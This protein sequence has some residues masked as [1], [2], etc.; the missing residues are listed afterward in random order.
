[1]VTTMRKLIFS[2]GFYVLIVNAYPEKYIVAQ[3]SHVSYKVIAKAAFGLFKHTIVGR[4]SEVSGEFELNDG[5]VR[6][7][8]SI[9]VSGFESGNTR[10][11]KD[12]AKILKV[13]EFPYISIEVDSIDTTVI[14]EGSVDKPV[15]IP[16]MLTV[17]GVK[18]KVLMKIGYERINDTLAL[19]VV[20]GETK[21]TTFNI[22][23]PS[24]RGLGV[25]GKAITYAPDQVFLKG[26]LFIK[27]FRRKE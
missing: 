13:D 1:M 2:T 20:N 16:V 11:D 10:R 4:N 9:P 27:P 25:I 15:S 5:I 24:I 6:G 26:R 23:P 18:R 7:K 21:F 12:V 17:A 8:L 3:E 22:D 19:V 14:V